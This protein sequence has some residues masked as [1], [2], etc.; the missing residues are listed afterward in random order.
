[1]KRRTRR[2]PSGIRPHPHRGKFEGQPLIA[3]YVHILTMDGGVDEEMSFD[4]DPWLGLIVL[5]PR[6]VDTFRDAVETVAEGYK[7]KLTREE[8]KL[9]DDLSGIILEETGQGFVNV[10]FYTKKQKK[11]LEKEWGKLEK[12]YERWEEKGGW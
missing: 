2:D 7:D 6:Q 4:G 12:E 3:E 1:M 5:Q 11:E 8:R 9:L 10:G